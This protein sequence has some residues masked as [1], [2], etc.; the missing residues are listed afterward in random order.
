VTGPS[1]STAGWENAAYTV[2]ASYAGATVGAVVCP[3][4]TTMATLAVTAPGQLAFGA[5]TYNAGGLGATNLAFVVAKGPHGNYLGQLEVITPDKWWFQANVTSYGKTSS[6]QGLLGGAGILYWW[7]SALNRGHGAWQL[8]HS[9]VSFTATANAGT[10]TSVAS[11][12]VTI[13]YTPVPP[14]PSPLPSSPPMALAKGG[15]VIS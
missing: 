5:G 14:Q 11:F 13:N 4:A 8:A 10:K 7:D 12:G 3:P 6:T 9:G 15:I 2:T 1:V